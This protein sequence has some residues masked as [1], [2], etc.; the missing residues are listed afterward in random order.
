MTMQLVMP[1]P[2]PSDT[3][4]VVDDF[5]NYNRYLSDATAVLAGPRVVDPKTRHVSYPGSY[6]TDGTFVWPESMRTE[7]TRG[8][9]PP[10][11]LRAHMETCAYVP[12]I[13][14]DE[15]CDEASRLVFSQNAQDEST[16]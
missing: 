11:V 8:M 10:A 16:D 7:L 14:T 6:R 15:Q 1:E 5:L 13:P 12:P 2:I 4:V 3:A 9:R